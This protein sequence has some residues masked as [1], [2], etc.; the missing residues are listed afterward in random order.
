MSGLKFRFDNSH[1][2]GIV[3]DNTGRI[4][5]I[6]KLEGVDI[7]HHLEALNLGANIEVTTKYFITLEEWAGWKLNGEHF[8]PDIGGTVTLPVKNLTLG[9]YGKILDI[10]FDELRWSDEK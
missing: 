9:N 2:D 5:L 8:V 4:W 10:E 7:K 1:G 6:T 3:K